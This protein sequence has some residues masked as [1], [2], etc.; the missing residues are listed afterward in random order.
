MIEHV[1]IE[2]IAERAF[3]IHFPKNVGLVGCLFIHFCV[4]ACSTLFSVTM[5]SMYL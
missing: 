1:D 3:Y 4:L 2:T 5:C